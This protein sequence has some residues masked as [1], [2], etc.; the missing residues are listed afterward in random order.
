MSRVHLIQYDGYSNDAY[1]ALNG[2]VGQIQTGHSNS[3]ATSTE[4]K[5]L[6]NT[7]FYLSQLSTISETTITD[8]L[9]LDV[10]NPTTPTITTHEFLTVLDNLIALS[11][12]PSAFT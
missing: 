2:N 10:D 9:A 3:N 6:A 7:L 11:F 1:L 5:I 12:C 8:N 4:Q